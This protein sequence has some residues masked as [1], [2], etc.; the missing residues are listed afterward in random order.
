[1]LML[2][3]P[4]GCTVATDPFRPETVYAGVHDE[5]VIR[6]VDGGSNW[7]VANKDLVASEVFSVASDP[8]NDRIAYIGTVSGLYKTVDSGVTW[9]KVF[10]EPAHFTPAPILDIAIHP[11][12]SHEVWISSRVRL[13]RSRDGGA[14]WS[15]VRNLVEQVPGGP[16]NQLVTSISLDER[17]VIWATGYGVWDTGYPGQI[18]KSAD[19]G[20]SFRS[21]GPKLGYGDFLMT[22][23]VEN[24]Q[25]IWVGGARIYHGALLLHSQDGGETWV[26]R[27]PP[28]GAEFDDPINTLLIEGDTILAGVGDHSGPHIIR[29]DDRGQTWNVSHA[30][31]SC[32]WRIVSSLT[33][34]GGVIY[35]SISIVMKFPYDWSLG[36]GVDGGVVVSTDGGRTW[37]TAEGAPDGIGVSGLSK[38]ARYAATLG[39]GV[40]VRE[41]D[42]TRRRA[43]RR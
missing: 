27:S 31:P 28:S 29:S 20:E 3:I 37:R 39:L 35:G 23:T 24:Q 36:L 9:Q 14:T 25:S 38:D 43:I 21:V 8:K 30:E 18:Y 26:D 1:M 40:F 11:I 7:T 15:Q 34:S 4:Y 41:D 22:L 17:G 12:D 5:G 6:S 13:W 16:S 19:G 32:C 10:T 33:R 2:L 42:R